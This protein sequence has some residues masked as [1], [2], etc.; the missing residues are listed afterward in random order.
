MM[1]PIFGGALAVIIVAATLRRSKKRRLRAKA[2]AHEREAEPSLA[3]SEERSGADIID[4]EPRVRHFLNT[5]SYRVIEPA[6]GA[7][8]LRQDNLSQLEQTEVASDLA[9]LDTFLIDVRDGLGADEAV[10]WRWSANR[11]RLSPTAWSTPGTKRPMF[12]DMNAWG[13]LV[14]WAAE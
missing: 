6:T 5:G 14:R 7:A 9:S 4:P 1:W 11:Q 13:S 3:I 10:F 8:A 2:E 12:F